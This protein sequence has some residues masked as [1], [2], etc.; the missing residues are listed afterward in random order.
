MSKAWMQPASPNNMKTLSATIMIKLGLALFP[1]LF[2]SCATVTRGIHDKLYVESQPPGASVLLSSG[3]KGVTP[4]KFVKSRRD[5]FTVTVSKPGYNAKTVKVESKASPT[6]GAAMA[7]NALAGGIIGIAIDS[8]TGAVFSLYPNP[9]SVQLVPSS[10]SG[11]KKSAVK[12]AA[13]HKKNDEIKLSPRTSR[14]A[15][16]NPEESNQ[17]SPSPS[18]SPAST[19]PE[20][21][22]LQSVETPKASPSP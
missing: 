13:R 5:S 14:P 20:P 9:V 4:T 7:G 1:F 2:V 11:P 17:S 21:R 8:G 16:A 18:P 22:T 6:G 3:E 12:K 19:P 10:R 15:S